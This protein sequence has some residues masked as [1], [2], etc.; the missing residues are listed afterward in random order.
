MS[1]HDFPELAAFRAECAAADATLAAVPADAWRLPALGEWSV[2]EL[3]AHLV[4]GATRVPV[5]LDASSE[6]PPDAVP[7]CDRVSYWRQDM[8]AVAPAVAARARAEA[9]GVDPLTWPARFADGWRATAERAAATGPAALVDALRGPMRLDEYLATRVLEV[10]VHHL[11]LR[12]ALGQPPAPTEDA[13]RLVIADLEGLLGEPKPRALG[14][15]RFLRV[16]TGRL[17]SDDPR[18]PVLR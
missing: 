6:L 13:A 15:T 17:P 12:T 5:Y 14:R 3:V 1:D 9:E 4:R 10:V 8:E 2:S 11:D 16:A 18:F 7:A